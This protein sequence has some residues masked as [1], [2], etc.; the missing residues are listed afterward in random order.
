MEGWADEEVAFVKEF[1]KFANERGIQAT[2]R[3]RLRFVDVLPFRQLPPGTTERVREMT[4]SFF[5]GWAIFIFF[6]CACLS[7]MMLFLYFFAS[8]YQRGLPLGC[9]MLLLLNVVPT[10]LIWPAIEQRV[11]RGDRLELA[12][13]TPTNPT[14]LEEIAY[15]SSA[16]LIQKRFDN[17]VYYDRRA[18]TYTI[19]FGAPETAFAD[20]LNTIRTGKHTR[21]KTDDPHA[22]LDR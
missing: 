5:V 18:P 19:F 11:L 3:P 22:S 1:Q 20:L 17:I 14:L 15:L 8:D 12:R 16:I 10:L 7:I 4:R 9:L 21:H 2:F 13:E 6:H